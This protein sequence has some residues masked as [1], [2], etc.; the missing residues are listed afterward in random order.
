MFSSE[1][2]KYIHYFSHFGQDNNKP[3][4][5]FFIRLK[6]QQGVVALEV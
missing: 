3:L 2:R 4:H 1:Q 5:I 6:R